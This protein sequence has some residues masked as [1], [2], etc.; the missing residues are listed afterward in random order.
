MHSLK[1]FDC[2]INYWLKR[3]DLL[4]LN[5]HL[6]AYSSLTELNEVMISEY[7]NILHLFWLPCLIHYLDIFQLKIPLL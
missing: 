7:P 5:S 4:Y 3:G 2:N 6:V 1:V